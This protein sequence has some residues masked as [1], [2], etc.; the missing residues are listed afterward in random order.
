MSKSM[1]FINH[2]DDPKVPEGMAFLV[3]ADNGWVGTNNGWPFDGQ[4]AL[5]PEAQAHA[6]T[7]AWNAFSLGILPRP[8][9]VPDEVKE[10]F[11]K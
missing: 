2:G 5:Y 9:A 3:M 1:G 7:Y 10:W 6:I 11:D 4:P 8:E